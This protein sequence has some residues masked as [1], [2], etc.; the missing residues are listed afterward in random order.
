MQALYFAKFPVIVT[1]IRNSSR[2][3][4]LYC[5]DPVT[6]LV[7]SITWWFPF[8]K[9]VSWMPILFMLK[10]LTV[11]TVCQLTHW[12]RVTYI[13][14]SKLTIIVSDMVCRQTIIW[15]NAGI[16]SMKLSIAPLGTKFNENLINIY[17]FSFKKMHLKMSSGN[18][19]H[20]VLASMC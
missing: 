3:T 13:C 12:G 14:V 15:T 4:F 7:T 17:I 5:E 19:L 11:A 10:G 1:L 16:L 20:F 2:A 8:I 9:L 6:E 18:W